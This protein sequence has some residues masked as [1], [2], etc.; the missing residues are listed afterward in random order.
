MPEKKYVIFR[1]DV[2]WREVE[3]SSSSGDGNK[4]H[5]QKGFEFVKTR[6]KMDVK[7]LKFAY[8]RWP[9]NDCH[10]ICWLWDLQF[11]AKKWKT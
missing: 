5:R 8:M 10:N 11:N 1:V 2:V 4:V 7:R 6:W 3:L 9:L